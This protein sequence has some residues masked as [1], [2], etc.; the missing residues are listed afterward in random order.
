M[1]FFDESWTYVVVYDRSW[2]MAKAVKLTTRNFRPAWSVIWHHVLSNWS[3]VSLPSAITFFKQKSDNIKPKRKTFHNRGLVPKTIG[4]GFYIT[5]YLCV[6]GK[7]KYIAWLK[8]EARRWELVWEFISNLTKMHVYLYKDY[9]SL[10]DIF[11]LL[12][13]IYV[14]FV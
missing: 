3:A 5:K 4:G 13:R 11:L 14:W 10:S 6:Q 12:W 7:K 8:R 9:F 1:F 2:L